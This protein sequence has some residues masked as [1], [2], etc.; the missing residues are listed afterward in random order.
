MISCTE[1]IPLYSEFFKF[2]EE[3]GGHD[4]VVKYW[5]HISD[6]GLGNKNDPHSLISFLEKYG[7]LEGG[8][9]Y[10]E[11]TLTEEACDCLKIYDYNKGY[12]YENMRHCPSRGML[13]ELKHVEPYYDYCEHCNVIYQRVLDKYDM[14]LEVDMSNVDKAQ[15][16]SLLYKKGNKPTDYDKIDDTKVVIDMKADDNKYL[17]RD[18]HVSGDMAIKY[19][20]EKFGE[21]E[22]INFLT[23]YVKNYYSPVIKDIK[24]RGLIAIKEWI[25]RV[26]EKEEASHL[27]HISI[28]GDTLTV[29]ID[30]SP[31]IEFM[32]SINIEP[33]KYYIEQTRTLYKAIAD[34]CGYGFSLDYYEDDG[35]TQFRFIKNA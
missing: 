6:N 35:K 12:Y 19:C 34:E 5:H 16:T 20:A 18:F 17:H 31:V 25:E 32:K 13:N 15:C 26:Y 24:N 14:V 1:F 11:H 28:N 4:E 2:L 23:T 10:W 29:N 21:Q 33:S 8:I 22:A 30:K 7:G 3:K 9:K 27:L